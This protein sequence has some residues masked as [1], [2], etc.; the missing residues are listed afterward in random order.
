MRGF[1][2]LGSGTLSL[3]GYVSTVVRWESSLDNGSSWNNIANTSNSY[4]YNNLNNSVQYRTYVKNGVCPAQ[5]SNAVNIHV[6]PAVTIANAGTDQQRCNVTTVSLAGNTPGSGTGK[7]TALP[8]NPTT[9]SFSNAFDPNTTVSGLSSGA[10]L[11]VWTISNALC[12]DSKDTVQIV[13]SAPT[14]PGTLT[15]DATVCATSNSG[16]LTLSGYVSSIINWESSLN[17]G[18]SWNTISQ[19]SNSYTY[20]NL[21]ASIQYRAFVQ[22]AV[23]PGQY[24]N[25]VSIHVVQPV[26][27][28]NAGSDQQLCNVTS[29]TL[30]GNT[31]TSGTGKWTALPSNPTTVSFTNLVDPNTSVNG[32]SSGTYRFEWTISN[33]LC[34]DSK[35]TVQI[36]VYPPTVAGTLTA[37]AFVCISGNSGTVSLS[38]YLGNIIQWEYSIDNGVNWRILN[39]TTSAYHYTDLTTTTLYRVMVQSGLCNGLYS[40]IVTIHVDPVSAGGQLTPSQQNVCSGSNTGSLQIAGFKGTIMQWESSVDNGHT[41]TVIKHTDSIY[42]YTSVT[43]TTWYRVLIESGVCT[44]AY[45]T[46][47]VIT[48]STPT[49]AGTASGDAIVCNADNTGLIILK[50]RTGDILHWESSVD[51][52]N[53]WKIIPVMSDTLSYINVTASSQYRALVKNGACSIQ[54]SNT[55]SIT[56]IDQVTIANAGAD[57]VLCNA[58]STL[59]L[60]ANTA[61]SGSGTWSFVSGPST[62][63]FSNPSSPNSTVTGLRTGTYQ[64]VWTISNGICVNSTDTVK[65]RVDNVSSEFNLSSINDCG[66]TTYRFYNT[67]QSVFGIKDYKWYSNGDTLISKDISLSFTTEGVRDISLSVVSNTGCIHTTQARYTVIVYE[68]PK[69]N[70]N[71]IADACKSQMLKVSS[72]INSQD[73][74]VSML[75]NLGNGI[76]KNDSIITVQYSSDGKYTIKLTVATINRCFDSVYKQIMIHALPAL[77]ISTSPTICKGDTVVLAASGALSY[78]WTDNQN[79][80]LCN[81]CGSARVKPLTN[82]QYKVIGYNEYGCSQTQTAQIRVV[83][84]FKMLSV[85][86][87]S[88]CAGQSRQLFASGATSYTWYPETGLSNKHSSSPIAS[89][90]ISTTYHVIGKDD[91]SCFTDTAEVH[92]AVGRSTPI[93]IGKDTVL[94][95]GTVYKLNATGQTQEIRKWTWS[96]QEE[97]SCRNCATPTVKVTNDATISCLAINLYGC[98]STDTIMIK[99]F[100]PATEIF[101][102]N[103]FTPDGDG[104]NDL[105]I[106]QGKGVKMIK[107]FRIFNRWGEVVFEKTNFMPGDP[108]YGWDGRVRGKPASPDI[109][110]YMCEVICEKGLPTI[111]KGNVG[112]LK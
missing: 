68:Y 62:V 71:A 79:N 34:T 27:I 86:G 32:L 106:V 29:A 50:G 40:N 63:Y 36:T 1:G 98:T 31:P 91:F 90:Q 17:N 64:F 8:S 102:P 46:V 16:T 3:S 61:Q 60:E 15:A 33:A 53:T 19:T 13:V 7:W 9:V 18:S 24:S 101:I 42:T 76:R 11:F 25:V 49:V 30:S 108:A 21:S 70:I 54:Y 80:V 104:I 69:A 43:T 66:K 92:I 74:I 48:V 20:N 39:L 59:K 97:L 65:I 78:I 14:V 41:W 23:C 77:T 96:S 83:Q 22:N 4:T 51:Q 99:T 103:A 73:S 55:I 87:D 2:V 5:Y 82:Q 57:Q 26:T 105:L 58:N 72:E 12:A 112:I 107:S 45:S 93:N 110:V 47:A 52:G 6:V 67:S 37:D 89:P 94:S 84:P 38:R 100:C 35:D 75:W 109:F 10:Y 88:L 56:V 95:A 85:K 81:G 44:A 28:A 111:F